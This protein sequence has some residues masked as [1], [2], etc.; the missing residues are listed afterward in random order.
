MENQDGVELRWIIMVLRRWWWVVAV[1]VLV[2]TILA[3]SFTT[4]SKP[5]Y[6][7]T[8]T[9]LIQPARDSRS[10]EASILT[11]GERLALTYSQ[12]IKSQPVLQ[13]VIDQEGL[14]MTP[15]KLANKISSSPVTDTQLLRITVRDSSPE[16]T[17]Y[18]A[19]TISYA[20]TSFIKEMNSERFATTLN[21]M[22]EKLNELDLT[23]Q[24]TRSTMNE[25]RASMIESQ[26]DLTNQE[27]NLR[28]YRDEHQ[29]LQQDYQDLQLIVSQLKENVSVIEAAHTTDSGDSGSVATVTLF[30]TDEALASTYIR[31]L[32]GQPVLE[33]TI[34]ILGLSENPNIFVDKITVD[35][36]GGTNLIRLRVSDTSE[37]Q[38][39]LI[40]DT[41]ARVF[42]NQVQELVIEPYVSNINI[43]S[44]QL[45]EVSDKIERTQL[46]IETLTLE[47]IQS[48]TELGR[49]EG[50]LTENQIDKRS[51]QHDI[52]SLS[53][54]SSDEAET[55]I[56]SELA[57]E[58]T[59]P[60]QR[61]RLYFLIALVIGL[62]VG[63]GL[64]FFL[65]YLDDTIKTP[66]DITETLG[67][68][69]LGSIP[70]VSNGEN[71]LVV[72]EQPRSPTAEA[73]RMLGTN[74]RFTIQDK[75]LSTLL[76]TSPE[77][78]QGKSM[79]VA[80]LGAAL[81][82]LDTKVIIIDADLRLPRQQILFNYRTNDGLTDALLYGVSDNLLQPTKI[83]N[84]SVLTSG[85]K[86]PPNPTDLLSSHSMRELLEQMT[87]LA[88]L[89]IIDSPPVLNIADTAALSSPV[90][91]VLVVLEAGVTKQT[92]AQQALINL[93]NVGANLIGAVLNSVP[94]HVMGSYYYH[95]G[96]SQ[97]EEDIVGTGRAGPSGTMA[98]NRRWSQSQGIM[99]SLR[100]WFQSKR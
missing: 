78:R 61:G 42:I 7:A 47:K 12:M 22:Q 54:T 23:I 86:L 94:K 38:A 56:L 58:P 89:I 32:T 28:D 76:V 59:R 2:T 85:R 100:G 10:S 14:Q 39:I 13:R 27:N 73:F 26:A 37:S 95:Q 40:A 46:D 5:V 25:Y 65:E 19:N 88:D 66:Q 16:Q 45:D 3:L 79:I 53:L 21:S 74:V 55:V 24:Q 68:S 57:Q 36:V 51:I 44:T 4:I 50:V 83:D 87:G 72:I 20:F 49:L 18:L 67:L 96:I 41:L 30:L 8:A 99:P 11:A 64:A 1:S 29:L 9:L 17:S 81:A 48:E 97:S 69:T 82:M 84:L 90:D 75:S 98:A 31:I 77:P 35:L 91:G 63:V 92:S 70:K 93:D 34:A 52:E 62:L 33:E 60:I 43:I 15:N 71:E 80:N 6:E